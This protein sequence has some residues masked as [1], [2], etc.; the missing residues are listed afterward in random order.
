[1]LIKTFR[2]ITKKSSRFIKICDLNP[3]GIYLLKMNIKS[4]STMYE[5]CSKLTIKTPEWRQWHSTVFI[6][7]VEQV[8]LIILLF[9]FFIFKK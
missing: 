5:I 6:I 4:T 3:T 7:T 8:S 2:A 9:L 1:M